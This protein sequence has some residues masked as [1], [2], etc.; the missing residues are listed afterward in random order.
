MSL[1]EEYYSYCKK[2]RQEDEQRLTMIQAGGFFECYDN[3]MDGDRGCG[4]K[5]SQLLTINLTRKNKNKASETGDENAFMCGF[6]LSSLNKYVTKL[7]DIG[8]SVAVYRQE[9]ENKKKRFLDGIYTPT[10]RMEQGEEE[11]NE[12]IYDL[13]FT[14]YFIQKYPV[15][16]GKVR[17]YEY[18]QH[19]CTIQFSTGK[20]YLGETIDY[21]YDRMVQQ[22]VTQNTSEEILCFVQGFESEEVM[23]IENMLHQPCSE[24]SP[25]ARIDNAA[26]IEN[27]DQF[28]LF[29]H[30]EIEQCIHHA[31][32]FIQN[33]DTYY[34][35]GLHLPHD[36]W[37]RNDQLPLLSYNRDL[38]NELFLF[39]VNENR[40]VPNM[41]RK[42][43][44]DILSVK[45]NV[46]AKRQLRRILKHPKTSS[47]E[48]KK[49]F[50][51]LEEAVFP[52]DQ[53]NFFMNLF[54]MEWYF[55]RWYRKNLGYKCLS[56]LLSAYQAM[57][58]WYPE[59]EPLN[60]FVKS[61]W[62]TEK[63]KFFPDLCPIYDDFF[64]EGPD[65]H[66]TLTDQKR[67]VYE[68]YSKL[69]K[70]EKDGLVFMSANDNVEEYYFQTTTK[71]W[72]KLSK[73]KQESFRILE[74]KTS[75]LKVV[76]HQAEPILSSL[77]RELSQL[78][79]QQRQKMKD[80]H[81]YF[82]Q[83]FETLFQEFNY[84]LVLDCTYSCLKDFFVQNDYCC[85]SVHE[86]SESF[87]RTKKLRH[88]I[89]EQ[90]R[91]D[92]L[93]VPFSFEM[94][95]TDCIGSLIYGMNSSGKSTFMKSIGLGLWLA[96]CGLFVPAESFDF[97][98]YAQIFSKFNHS[99]NLYCGHSLF[100]S[101]MSDLDYILKHSS[102][103]TLL[104]MDELTSGTEVHS[105]SSL[106]IAMIEEFLRQKITFCFTTHIHWI[107]THLEQTKSVQLYHFTF[108]DKKDI[109][110]E[111]LLSNSPSDFYNRE[112][113]S[114]S[115]RERYGIEVAEKVGIHPR[116][117][118]RAFEIRNGVHFY[119]ETYNPQKISRYHPTLKMDK[120]Y[121]CQDTKNL[122]C[123]HI[124]PQKEFSETKITNGFRKDAK[125]NLLVLCQACHD[126][127][128]HE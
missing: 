103:N 81:N 101:E 117:I 42:T 3:H 98:P 95:K 48:I 104:L 8:Y 46:M 94:N 66:Q 105:A 88:V 5:L 76:P 64:L 50:V 39:N 116:I 21:E 100:V 55:I 28:Q 24:W 14:V 38:F 71:K 29:H 2:H 120:C 112:L 32:A 128:H 102:E 85:P 59:L 40:Q 114:G 97:A 19:L 45:M 96:Q 49:S 13:S 115:G 9:P 91:K 108:D 56:K 36:A 58:K 47:I 23:T 110:K 106:I 83:T 11:R 60:T 65:A 12:N 99:D 113:C 80:Y 52:K 51:R 43:V 86:N 34:L 16:K 68:L 90:L 78:R 27:Y 124:L 92:D 126:K 37:L 1:L 107:G 122:H 72:N 74:K 69:Q 119:Y 10:I 63:M 109:R 53:T 75:I 26:L 22:F 125:Y 84:K 31:V 17:T 18:S 6:P 4:A 121:I 57:E 93:F 61:I 35:K 123:H 77:S 70:F 111:K 82:F 30:P 73:S 87:C 33:H 25:V 67:T 127:I 44:F 7:N 20:V 79:E 62:D 118:K 54:D 89:V 41:E 15:Q